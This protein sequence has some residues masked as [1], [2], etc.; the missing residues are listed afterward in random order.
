MKKKKK[1]NFKKEHTKKL[2][3]IYR[4]WEISWEDG[5]YSDVW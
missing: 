4:L 5:S 3:E 2:N 1:I